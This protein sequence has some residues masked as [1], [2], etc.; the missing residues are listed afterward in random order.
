MKFQGVRNR[1]KN[2]RE[3]TSMQYHRGKG[4]G[5]QILD[6]RASSK[7]KKFNDFRGLCA[8]VYNHM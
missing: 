1:E 5:A 8:Q 7:V 4:S 6:V 3:K 2:E